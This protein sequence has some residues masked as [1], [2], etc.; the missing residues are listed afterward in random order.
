MA[1]LQLSATSSEP[2]APNDIV[3][4]GNTVYVRAIRDDDGPG[5]TYTVVATVTDNAGN[6]TTRQATC[7]VPHHRSR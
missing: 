7:L 4:V 2:A 3:I 1:D 6:V 5:R